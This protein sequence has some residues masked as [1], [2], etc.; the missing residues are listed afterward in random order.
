M[1]DHNSATHVSEL[2]PAPGE[3]V[4]SPALPMYLIVL[5]GGIPGAMIRLQQGGT[6]LGRSPDNT[7][8]LP[9]PGISRY[10]AVLR[11][12]EDGKVRITDLASTNGTRLN[13]RRLPNHTPVVLHDGDR[14]QFGANVIFKFLRPDPYEEQFQREMFERTVRDRLTGLY[15][16]SY[17]LDQTPI[18]FDQSALKDLG[19]AILMVDIDHFK[20]VN[21][22][23]GHEVGDRVLKEIAGVIRQSTRSQD[24]VARYGGEEFIVALPIAAQDQAVDRAE[25]IRVSVA[26]KGIDIGD[27]TVRMTTSVGLAFSAAGRPRVVTNL[28]AAADLALY[29]A[30]RDG[31]NRV[32]CGVALPLPQSEPQTRDDDVP[33][34]L[35]VAE[36]LVDGAF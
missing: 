7:V 15:N 25:R 35:P 36:H 21:D 10:H 9:D 11:T 13:G 8:Q 1:D 6:R 12:G 3:R 24:L 33:S 29:Q 20:Q 14:V 30:K 23:F 18:L 4:P 16:R 34:I 19:F 22:T 5:G 2:L 28:I 27:R 31:R 26:E 32:V 17:F